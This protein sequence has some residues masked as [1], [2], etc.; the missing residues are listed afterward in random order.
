[1]ATG[2]VYYE[3]KIMASGK[4][5]RA[6][7]RRHAHNIFIEAVRY[8]PLLSG[9]PLKT[10]RKFIEAYTANPY[11]W[12]SRGNS[13]VSEETLDELIK[14]ARFIVSLPHPSEETW[15][16]IDPVYMA[17]ALKLMETDMIIKSKTDG[18]AW[19]ILKVDLKTIQEQLEGLRT[20]G[21]NISGSAWG[22]HISVIRGEKVDPEIWATYPDAGKIITFELKDLRHNKNGYYWYDVESRELELLRIQHK[23]SPRPTPPFHLTIGK[24]Q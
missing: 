12:L 19:C 1:M 14:L 18:E 5:R 13:A 21:V 20:A 22:P 8:L 6:I 7:I 17:N 11:Y 10:L 15:K 4:T 16:N 23:L 2:T 9:K 3:P 24:V